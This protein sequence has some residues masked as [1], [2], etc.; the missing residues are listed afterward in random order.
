MAAESAVDAKIREL[1]RR[2]PRYPAGAYHFLFE[3]LDFTMVA[4]GRHRRRGAE[5]HLTVPELLDGIRGFAVSQYGP[6]AR[7]VLESLG[8]FETRDFG[9]VVFNLVEAGLLNKQDSDHR[10]QFAEGFSF[11]EAFRESV[12]SERG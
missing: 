12:L 10:E 3:A 6:L 9:D 7:V 8:C 2:D 1:V 4:K 11:R 5:R